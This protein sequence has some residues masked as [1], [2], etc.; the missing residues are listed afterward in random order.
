MY[1]SKDRKM[2]PEKHE[3][4]N[5]SSVIAHIDMDAFFAQVEEKEYPWLK[6]K[7][8]VVGGLPGQRGVA[9]TCNYEARKYGVHSGMPLNECVRLCPNAVFIRTHGRKYSYI[10]LRVQD[11]LN[12]IC[13]E[14]KMTS[15]DEGYLDM[16]RHTGLYRDYYDIGEKIR[17]AVFASVG[18]TCSVG[19]APNKYVAKVCTGLN[20]PDGLTVMDVEEFRRVFA[21]KK[22]S[23]LTGVG[24]STEKSL[25]SLGIITIG[26]LQVFPDKILEDRFGVYGPRMKKLANGIYDGS[27]ML[28]GDQHVEKSVGHE[29]TFSVDEGSVEEMLSTLLRLST[30][31]ARRLREGKYLGRRITL[32]LRYTD[33]TTINH[34]T[35][36][37]FFTNNED[38][39]YLTVKKCF[40]EVYE[41]GKKIR[42]IGVRVS[43]LQQ[44]TDS[45]SSYQGDLFRGEVASKKNLVLKAA[46]TLRDKFGDEVL[47]YAGAS[48]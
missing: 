16:T 35:S 23:V 22:V 1:A 8:V 41:P 37:N 18:L 29:R 34:Q 43:H 24:E 27:V 39:I 14:V 5:W 42:L 33:F 19:V 48:R 38:E 44:T 32:K 7:P 31:A 4:K 47:Y 46:D 11:A 28:F 20:K 45:Y 26:Q 21:P 36:M 9:S 3:Y 15:I 12:K 2:Y 17:K 13:D 25:N 30:K 40:D 6:G 10:S